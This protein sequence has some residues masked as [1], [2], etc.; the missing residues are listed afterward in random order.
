MPNKVDVPAQVEKASKA[1]VDS[2]ESPIW[3]RQ[4]HGQAFE[5]LRWTKDQSWKVFTWTLIVLGGLNAYA[6]SLN[7]LVYRT[8]AAGF[9]VSAVYYLATLTISGDESREW[10]RDIEKFLKDHA[11]LPVPPLAHK[12]KKRHW[13]TTLLQSGIVIAAALLAMFFPGGR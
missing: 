8:L 5:H 11:G 13:I 12:G 2:Q 10:L 7:V 1:V 4:F 9:A 3:M 6:G